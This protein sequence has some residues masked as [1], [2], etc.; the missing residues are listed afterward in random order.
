MTEFFKD[1]GAFILSVLAFGFS[2]FTF[3]KE[4]DQRTIN[5]YIRERMEKEQKQEV[6]IDC[7]IDGC[8]KLNGKI[9]YC[10]QVRNN[11]N[12]PLKNVNLE[13]EYSN[14]AAFYVQNYNVVPYEVLE[15][16]KSFDII[17]EKRPEAP[18]KFYVQISW[19]NEKGERQKIN[20]LVS[21]D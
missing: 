2:M 13:T 9:F 10:L 16:H 15:P 5:K 18:E 21:W 1:W 3:W 12:I 8:K 19:E 4:E 6:Q 11:G 20:R 7:K 17:L 14:Y